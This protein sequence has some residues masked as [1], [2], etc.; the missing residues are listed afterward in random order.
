[1]ARYE[2]TLPVGYRLRGGKREYVI[3]DILG[4]GGFGITYKVKARVYVDNISVDAHFAVKEYFPDICWRDE[5][6]NA[7]LVVPKTKSEEVHDGI[8]DFL[9]EGRRLQGVCHLNHNIVNVNEVFEAN[10]TAYYVLEYL[11]GGD[12]RKRLKDNGKPFTEEQMLAL[13][14]PIAHAVQCLHD[15]SILH[16]DI[17]PSNIVMRKNEGEEVEPVLI[18][19]GIAVH[20]NKSGTPTS[21]MPSLGVSPGYSPIEQYSELRNF[22]P[23]LDIYAFAATCLYLLTGKDPI[24]ALSM[25]AGFVHDAI[26]AEVSDKVRSAIVNAMSKEKDCRTASINEMFEAMTA[27]DDASVADGR[28]DESTTRN[29]AYVA[30]VEQNKSYTRHAAG[31]DNDNPQNEDNG[32]GKKKIIIIIAAI[33]A[34]VAIIAGIIFGMKGCEGGKQHTSSSVENESTSDVVIKD[35]LDVISEATKDSRVLCDQAIELLEKAQTEEDLQKAER[36]TQELYETYLNKYQERSMEDYR[37]FEA[38]SNKEFEDRAEP[39]LK[40]VRKRIEKSKTTADN[41]QVAEKPKQT[42]QPVKETTS[43]KTPKTQKQTTTKQNE[44]TPTNPTRMIKESKQ[45][46]PTYD[47]TI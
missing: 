45:T 3:E 32:N 14:T 12:L 1:M 9:N 23:R 24:E 18:D 22:D 40:E 20:F 29:I 2:N 28:D 5:N 8:R 38:I 39:I 13:M 44:P 37:I 19:F 30:P 34:S 36:E 15:N 16:L 10:G 47:R 35:S 41:N 33:L 43:K 46:D 26:P 11:E 25:P 17:K 7:T 27:E 21:K 42:G 31:H 6:D 4:R